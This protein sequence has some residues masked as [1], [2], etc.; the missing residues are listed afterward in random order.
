MT[1]A[2]ITKDWIQLAPGIRRK[3]AAVGDKM[4]QVVVWFDKGAK[5]PE[6]AH[7][8]EQIAAVIAGKMRFVVAG[9]PIE[10]SDGSV[11]LKSNVPH[12][13][14]AL[15]ESWLLDTFSPLREDMLKV[16]AEHAKKS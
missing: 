16:D 7:V 2:E 11:M 12:S 5:L 1:G 15:E 9:K 14:E 4:M 3:T 10:I 6:H 13:A 8:H